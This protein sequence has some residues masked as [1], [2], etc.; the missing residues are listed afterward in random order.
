VSI[1]LTPV[2]GVENEDLAIN[3]ML[4]FGGFFLLTFAGNYVAGGE[5]LTLGSGS[6][7]F[8]T[9]L[10][11]IGAGTLYYV[12]IQM[13]AGYNFEYDYATDKILVKQGG[14]AVSNPEAEIAAAA[15][16][17]ALTSLAGVN[18]VRG[19]FLGR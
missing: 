7:D 6:Y 15:Y 17:A 10:K 19:L 5:A 14:A 1:T 18:R 13:K 16:P 4:G 12:T 8:K 11:R 9:M 3:H 2:R